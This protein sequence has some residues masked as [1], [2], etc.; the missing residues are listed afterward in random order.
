MFIC[1]LL[2]LWEKWKHVN[3]IPRKSQENAG[4]ILGQS[5]E[6]FVCAFLF[7]G[8]FRVHTHRRSHRRNDVC[9]EA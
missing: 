4:R 6:H 1:C 8:F 2:F 5:R 9:P 3:K 7:I